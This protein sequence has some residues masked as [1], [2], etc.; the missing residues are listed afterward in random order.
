[1]DFIAYPLG[2]F[3]KFIYDT[4]AFNNYGLAIIIFTL[5]VRL[6]MLPLTLK[7]LKSAAKANELQ[8]LIADIQKRYKDD[9]EKMNQEMLKLYQEHNYNPA[10][11][12]LPLLIQFP[13]I[14]TLY[15]VI[16]Q[17]LKF[18]LGKPKETI[19]ALVE[20]ARKGLGYTAQQMMSNQRELITLNYFHDNPGALS[21]VS[22][23]LDKSELIDFNNFLGLRLGMTA[24]YQPSYLFGPDWKIYLPLFLLVVIATVTTYLSSKLAM[25]R[26]QNNGQQNAAANSMSNSFL[27]IGPIMTLMF[28]FSLPAGV[29][30]YW[31]AGYVF[32]IFQQLYINKVVYKKE[33]SDSKVADKGKL[34]D[35]SKA[36]EGKK[37]LDSASPDGT[38]SNS[39]TKDGSSGE[40]NRGDITNDPIN[41]GKDGKNKNISKKKKK[42]K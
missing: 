42:K 27:Y 3:M 15:W 38:D 31:T 33:K 35:G 7:Q 2:K 16:V 37:A 24:K 36:G 34:N 26:P 32:A 21:E 10:G 25:Y 1:M 23:M 11:G 17:P 29:I 18:M 12:C 4:I 20:V 41:K 19:D 6:A 39:V 5:I 28:S 22:G 30:L 8:P 40:S 9:R 14:I 13:I